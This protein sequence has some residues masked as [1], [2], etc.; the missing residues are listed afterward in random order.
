MDV[1]EVRASFVIKIDPKIDALHLEILKIDV[2]L[3][4]QGIKIFNFDG[5]QQARDLAEA[6]TCYRVVEFDVV[7]L[8]GTRWEAGVKVANLRADAVVCECL[9]DLVGDVPIDVAQ[10]KQEEDEQ[11]YRNHTNADD[12]RG[13]KSMSSGEATPTFPDGWLFLYTHNL[14]SERDSGENLNS[15][16]RELKCRL[17]APEVTKRSLLAFGPPE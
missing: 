14:Q 15:R 9:L 8:D 12:A 3:Q 2:A 4:V 6:V 16:G 10:A 1:A 13:D 17:E 11:Q 5:G 7:H